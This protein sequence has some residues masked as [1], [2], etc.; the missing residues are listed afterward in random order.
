M[1]M[2]ALVAL[3]LAMAMLAAAETLPLSTS[4]AGHSVGIVEARTAI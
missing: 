2:L 1:P 3:T 4:N